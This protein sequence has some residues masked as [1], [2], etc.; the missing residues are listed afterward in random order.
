MLR[1]RLL[2]GFDLSYGDVSLTGSISDRLQSLLTYLVL[3]RQKAQSRQHL[4]FLFWADSTDAQARTNLRRIIHELRQV[5]PEVEQFIAID[6]KT[7]QWRLDAPFTL[8][9]ME[10]EQAIA[11]TDLLTLK[12]AADLY[13]GKLLP[14]C[15]DEWIEPEQERLQQVCVQVYSRLIQQLLDIQDYSSAIRYGQQL[16]RI[17]PLNETGYFDL[18]HSYAL[19]GDRANAL[20]AYHRCMTVLRDELGIDPSPA[21]RNLYES[22]LNETDPDLMPLK[23]AID[24]GDRGWENTRVETWESEKAKNHPSTVP[25]P[26]PQTRHSAPQTDWGEATDVSLFYGRTQELETLTQWIV[27]DRC[28]VI[29]LLGMGGIGKTSLSVKL[30]QQVSGIRYQVSGDEANLTPHTPQPTD[31]DFIIWRSLRNSPPLETLLTELVSF[32]SNQQD[33]ESSLNR[34]LHWLRQSRC[35]IVLDNIEPI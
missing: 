31:F 29:T 33:T 23:R 11:V 12:R 20:Q 27:G 3:N 30:A 19:S 32:L 15:Y 4:A 21:T 17:D 35:L 18:M 6:N 28:R 1:I 26:T 34:L 25:H 13:R 16:L 22:L 7:L 24:K 10:F 14:N 5:L 9:V 2:G 8:D